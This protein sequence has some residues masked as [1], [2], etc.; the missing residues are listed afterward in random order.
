MLN[1]IFHP[2]LAL[3]VSVMLCTAAQAAERYAIYLPS[4]PLNITRDGES[5]AR[6]Q[7]EVADSEE[8]RRHGLMFRDKLSPRSGM[9]F[10]Y[11][12]PQEAAMWMKNTLIPLDM[13]FIDAEQRIIHIHPKATPHS[14]DAVS[15]QQDVWGVLELVGG[16]AEALDIRMG[17][18]INLEGD[19][20]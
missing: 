1:R 13:L 4:Q 5:V 19:N 2:L 18:K 6:I 17:D 16:A 9:L 15:A 7:A 12:P 14:L 8:E 3:L 10:I 11:S 20:Q